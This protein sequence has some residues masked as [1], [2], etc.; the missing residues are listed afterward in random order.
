MED[1]D[2]GGLEFRIAACESVG[3]SLLVK[4]VISTYSLS[5]TVC[6]A[7]SVCF[8][9]GQSASVRLEASAELPHDQFGLISIMRGLFPCL[10]KLGP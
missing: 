10:K 3:Q 4:V 2:F 7:G 9:H 1:L 6:G 5:P 8:Y